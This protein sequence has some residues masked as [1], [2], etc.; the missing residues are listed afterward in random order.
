MSDES[1]I[2][3]P[4][5]TDEHGYMDRECPSETCMFAFKIHEDD[6]SNI[7]RDEE[8]FCP[9]CRHVA[10]SDAWWT[11]A[12]LDAAQDQAVA[13]VQYEIGSML[14]G[15][16]RSFNRGRSRSRFLQARMQN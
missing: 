5:E 16:A 1:E 11:T 15:F 2:S 6:W 4:V 8:V 10:D 13:Q 12:Q 3:F 9:S 14:D 7:V